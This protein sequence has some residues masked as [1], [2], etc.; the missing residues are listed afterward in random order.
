[1][2]KPAKRNLKRFTIVKGSANWGVLGGTDPSPQFTPARLSI[3]VF[4][5]DQS[6]IDDT[7]GGASLLKTWQKIRSQNG[8]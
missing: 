8:P 1:M 7:M 4:L 3:I 2:K 6:L 5:S